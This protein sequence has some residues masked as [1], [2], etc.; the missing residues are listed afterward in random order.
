MA[1][2]RPGDRGLEQFVMSRIATMGKVALK[3]MGLAVFL[4]RPGGSAT[5]RDGLRRAVFRCA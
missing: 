3:Q 1:S 5:G 4:R 2:R